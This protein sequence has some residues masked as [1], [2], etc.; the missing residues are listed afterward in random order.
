MHSVWIWIDAG[1]CL[2]SLHLIKHI[3]LLH[4]NYLHYLNM[5]HQMNMSA[6]KQI[7]RCTWKHTRAAGQEEGATHQSIGQRTSRHS[8]AGWVVR[9]RHPFAHSLMHSFCWPCRRAG[10]PQN[11]LNAGSAQRRGSVSTRQEPCSSLVPLL[12]SGTWNCFSAR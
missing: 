1:P 9:W 10:S 5:Y 8:C 7:H 6:L 12:I 3:S 11:N 4:V 2:V